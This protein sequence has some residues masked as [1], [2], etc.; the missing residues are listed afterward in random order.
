M[1]WPTHDAGPARPE[2][3]QQQRRGRHAAP[4]PLLPPDGPMPGG[5]P[6]PAETT[7]PLAL[8]WP[9]PP[10]RIRAP[11]FV[12]A[13]QLVDTAA[14]GAAPPATGPPGT[15][16]PGAPGAGTAAPKRPL[17]P[18]GRRVGRPSA[19]KQDGYGSPGSLSLN[20]ASRPGPGRQRS[21]AGT[22]PC[23]ATAPRRR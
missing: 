9:A 11:R 16:G 4:D 13:D 18:P 22:C 7:L 14:P 2:P 8:R 21:Q 12:P 20:T 6:T 23:P 19:Y 5:G 3:R 17:P 1:T 15:A 10:P